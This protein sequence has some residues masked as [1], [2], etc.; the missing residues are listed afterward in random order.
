MTDV[1]PSIWYQLKLFFVNPWLLA[2]VTST[3]SFVSRVLN[4]VSVLIITV[5]PAW[6]RN[7]PQ[8]S[9]FINFKRLWSDVSMDNIILLMQFINNPHQLFEISKQVVFCDFDI[10]VMNPVWKL[11]L[12][13]VSCKIN[14]KYIFEPLLNVCTIAGPIRLIHLPI[15]LKESH[16]FMS[17]G[18]FHYQAINFF[19]PIVICVN[20]MELMIKI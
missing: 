20:I 19:V 18:L 8:V 14:K 1:I 17:K 9:H 5:N 6:K 7:E 12:D 3:G 15:I 4:G 2:V 11:S 13:I 10:F 16:K